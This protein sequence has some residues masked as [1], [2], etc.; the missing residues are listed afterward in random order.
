MVNDD[1]LRTDD[2][3]DERARRMFLARVARLE[4]EQILGLGAAAAALVAEGANKERT[5]KGFLFAWYDGPRVSQQERYVFGMYFQEVVAAL[6]TALTGTDPH[7]LAPPKSRASGITAVFREA[8]LPRREWNEV[9]DIGIRLVENS[10]AP[11][12]VQPI[13][14][15]AWNAGCTV[16]MRGRLP[17]EL[18]A[19]LLAPWMRAVGEPPV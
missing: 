15:A 13:V 8:F 5:T 1:F 2:P 11:A 17:A 19:T 10:V 6:A 3:G 14:T 7:V 12:P 9:G 4:R 18:E 16:W